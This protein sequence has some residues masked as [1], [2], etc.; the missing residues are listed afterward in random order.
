VVA[1]GSNL[2]PSAALIRAAFQELRRL[3][4]RGFAASSLWRS[5]PVDCPPGSPDFINAACYFIPSDSETPESLLAKLQD[6]ERSFGRTPKTEL[7]EARRLDLDLIGF[8]HEKR[9]TANLRLPHPRA[10]Q[11][12]FVLAPMNEL[13]PDWILPG[14]TTSVSGYLSQLSDPPGSTWR[15]DADEPP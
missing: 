2:G 3:S 7:N 8:G 10:H 1:L 12:R 9:D 11:R 13:G 6:L 15:M 14:W 5:E 4:K